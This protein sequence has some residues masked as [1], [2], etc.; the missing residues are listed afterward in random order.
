MALLGNISLN[1]KKVC[2]V[3]MSSIPFVQRSFGWDGG[4]DFFWRVR[5]KDWDEIV[6]HVSVSNKTDFKTN[7]EVL[8]HIGFDTDF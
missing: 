7:T 2:N 6:P 3:R 5:C 4:N 1:I 8:Q